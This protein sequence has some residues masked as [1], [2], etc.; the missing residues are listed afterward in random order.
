MVL[1]RGQR[2]AAAIAAE[3]LHQLLRLHQAEALHLIDQF[4]GDGEVAV[5][6]AD[7]ADAATVVALSGDFPGGGAADQTHPA[8][9][10]T[11]RIAQRRQ[12]VLGRAEEQH[13]AQMRMHQLACQVLRDRLG[14]A[15]FGHRRANHLRLLFAH[16]PHSRTTESD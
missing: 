2:I 13:E 5:I 1:D 16:A 6:E 7:G 4:A 9:V 12:V 15:G 14:L 8:E 10:L 3:A 11:Q